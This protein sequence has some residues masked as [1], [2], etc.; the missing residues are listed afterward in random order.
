[1]WALV[2]KSKESWE[3]LLIIVKPKGQVQRTL[4]WHNSYHY[5]YQAKPNQTKPNQTELNQTKPNYTY[6]TKAKG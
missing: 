1:M 4:G 3:K 6:G 5:A 2:G